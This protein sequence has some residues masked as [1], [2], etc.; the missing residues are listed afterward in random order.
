MSDTPIGELASAT[1]IG[2][3]DLFLLQQGNAAKKLPGEKLTEYVTRNVVNVV[4]NYISA[5]ETESYSYTGDETHGGTLTLNIRRGDGIASIAK[6]GTS[7]VTDTYTITRDSG[8]TTTFTVKN[9]TSIKPSGI[10]DTGVTRTD[11]Q[12]RTQHKFS[13]TL[14]DNSKS[15]FWI[16]DGKDGLGTVNTVAGVAPDASNDVP[17][18]SL[19]SALAGDLFDMFWPVGSI[20]MSKTA[21]VNPGANNGV[22]K[23]GTWVQITDH[24]IYAAG[25]KGINAT[26]GSETQTADFTGM[27]HIAIYNQAQNYYLIMDPKTDDESDVINTYTRYSKMSDFHTG[28][29]DDTSTGGHYGTKV[30][31][32]TDSFD[33]MPPFEVA[34]MWKRTA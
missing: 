6:T 25:T 14:T 11:D 30:T 1:T 9:G 23:R 4:V 7:G 32:T 3:N 20:Y 13:V 24:F 28:S 16:T 33:N 10:A 21:S 2:D 5:G 17:E 26:G 15:Y 27:A 12:G 34:Y 19:I 18:A 8:L 31:G 29:W 22:F